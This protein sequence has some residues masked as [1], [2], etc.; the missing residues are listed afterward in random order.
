MGQKNACRV[1]RLPFR[2]LNKFAFGLSRSPPHTDE[3]GGVGGERVMKQK[4][5]FV[6]REY[7]FS[8]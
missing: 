7:L 3:G 8:L 6:G 1:G 2:F 5:A 4:N